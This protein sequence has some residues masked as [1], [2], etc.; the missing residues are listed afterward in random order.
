[1]KRNRI[2]DRGQVLIIFVFAIVGLIGM[3][4]LAIDGGNIYS[5]RR[6]AQ[7]AADTASLAAALFRVNTQ[8]EMYHHPG[9]YSG[10]GDCSDLGDPNNPGDLPST[11][12][13][14]IITVALDMA[15]E[16]GYTNNILDSH[17]EVNT[18][19]TEGPYSVAGVG[20]DPNQY[21]EVIIETNVSTFFARVLGVPT[22]HNHVQAVARA[23]YEPPGSLYGGNALVALKPEGDDCSGDFNLGGSSTVILNGGGVFI[24]STNECAAFKE[25]SSCVTLEFWNEDHTVQLYPVYDEYGNIVETGFIESVPGAGSQ[26]S[27][28]P[29]APNLSGD[30]DPYLFPPEPIIDPEPE[31]CSEP[32]VGNHTDADGYAHLN[33]GHYA[34]L[35]PAKNTH[36]NPG[37]YCV[38]NLIKVTNPQS[39]LDVSQTHPEDG[40]LIYIRDGG[41]FDFQGGTV[42]LNASAWPNDK[43]KGFLIY[44]AH[45]FSD[46]NPADPVPNCQINGNSSSTFKGTIY[47]PYCDVT[48]NGTSDA[49]GFMAQIIAY[50]I[51]LSG[52]TAL[53]FTYKEEDQGTTP[54]V[55]MMGLSR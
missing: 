38:D 24:N 36:L 7:N 2:T 43:Y 19:P 8:R 26:I 20:I 1:M 17:V 54:E 10:W 41:A 50:T 23:R 52:D 48:I 15:E 21:V 14:K 37:V 44:M 39:H 40:V 16:N 46:Y 32:P 29:N 6:H 35:P 49:Q 12:G 34:S 30:A 3:T 28:C 22:M 45:D 18:P 13:S 25:E 51:S 55:N 53:Q 11:C 47:A 31:E 4:G 33:P 5:D 9:S 42:N 27:S